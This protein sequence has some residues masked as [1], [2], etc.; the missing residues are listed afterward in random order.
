MRYLLNSTQMKACDRYTIEQK[1]M[2]SAVLM[3][4]AAL[5]VTEEILRYFPDQKRVLVLCGSGNNGGDGFAVARLLLLAGVR[6]EVCFAGQERSLTEDAALQKKIFENYGGK[7]CRN[8]QFEEY[9]LLVDALFGIGL[10]RAVEGAYAALLREAAASGL[11]VVAVDMPSGISADTGAVMGTALRADLTVTFAFA[12]PGQILYPGTEYCGTLKVRDIGVANPLFADVAFIYEKE[13]LFRLLPKR[14]RR[15]NKGTYGKVLVAGAGPGMAG[16]AALCGRG[17]YRTGCGLVRLLA[18]DDCRTALQTL[19]PEA[20]YTAWSEAEEEADLAG[21]V[22]W[23]DV[24][25]VGPGLGRSRKAERF[26]QR[27]LEI[28]NGPLVLD[29]DALNLLAAHP[30]YHGKTSARIIV[31]PH[32]GEMSR[33]T[34]LPVGAILEDIP[35]TAGRYAKEHALVCVLKDARTA[36]ADGARLYLNTSGNDGMAVGGSGDVLTGILCGLLAQGMAEYEAACL[37]VYLHGLCGDAARERLGAR[38]MLASD[39]IDSLAQELKENNSGKPGRK[40]DCDGRKTQQ[41]LCED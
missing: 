41:G 21:L 33:L 8:P 39:L 1:G 28:W 24:I 30:E 25:A 26:L 37:G 20:L 18:A 29:A 2:P 14:S 16:A 23:A 38:S 7:L 11:P 3:E 32:P 12:K 19:L 34:G 40:E 36:V 5:A 6:A 22:G 13:D 4:R 31:T 17:A 27:V 15:S 10:S 35:G 9:T